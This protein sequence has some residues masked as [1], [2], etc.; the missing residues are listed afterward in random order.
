MVKRVKVVCI[1]NF[2]STGNIYY[3]DKKDLYNK[4]LV[5]VYSLVKDKFYFIH[6][7]KRNLFVTI[8]EWREERIN[9]ILE[10]G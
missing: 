8:N 2:K 1:K 6:N 3:I 4:E 5:S 7:F 9:K 10:D